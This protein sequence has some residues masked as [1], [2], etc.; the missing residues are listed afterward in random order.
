M[1][2]KAGTL[3]VLAQQVGQALQPLGDQ[4]SPDNLLPFLAGLGLQFPRELTAQTAFMSAA[5]AGAVAAGGL[6]P[7]L[8]RLAAAVASDDEAGILAAGLTL[9][10]QIGATVAALE[11]LGS[12]LASIAGSLPGMDASEVAGFAATLGVDLLDSLLITYLRG[13]APGAVGVAAALGLVEVLPQ[14]GVPFDPTHPPFLRQRFHLA[15]LGKLL[16]SPTALLRTLYDWGD[17]AFDATKLLP[18]LGA[19]FDLLGFSAAVSGDGPDMALTSSLLRVQANPATSPPGLLATIRYDIASG[20]DLTLPL[21]AAWSVRVQA[22]GAIVAGIAAS[23]APPANLTLLPPSGTLD[24]LLRM[25]LAAKGADAAHPFILLGETGGSRLQADTLG[26]GAGLAL[27]WDAGSGRAIAEPQ[28]QLTVAGGKAVVDTTNADGFLA[29]VLGGVH[30]EA[31][32]DLGVSWAPDTG[33]H[34]TGGAQLEIDL[35]L[36]LSLGP[37]TLSTLYLVA[38]AGDAGVPLEVSAALGLT[39][40][41]LQVAV[42]RIG[43]AGLLSFPDH[44]GNLGPADLALA[45][46][47][48][49]GLGIAIDAGVVAGGGY[50]QFDPQQGRYAGVLEVTLAEVIQVKVVAVLDTRLPDGSHGYSFLLVI[51]FDLPPI[52]LGL[53]FTLDG[54]GGLGAVNRTLDAAALQAGLRA[55]T[56]DRIL[57]PPDPIAN[58]PQIVA[59]IETLFPP[60]GGRYLFGPMLEIGWGTPTLITFQVGIVLE[61]PDPVRLVL[62]GLI[63]AGLPTAAAALVEIHVDVLGQL[64]FGAKTLAIDGTLHDSRVLVYALAGDLALRLAWGDDPNFVFALGGCNPHFDTTG[65]DLPVL[66]R[67]SLG[68]GNG[69]NPRLSSNSYLAVTSSTVQFGANVEVQASAADFSLHGYLGFDALFILSP[70]SFTVDF[71]ADL[72]VAFDGQALGGLRI[73]GLFSGPRPWHLH[74]DVSIDILFFSVSASLDLTWGDATPAI[75]PQRAVLPDLLA[76]LAE[77]RNWQAALPDGAALAVTLASA[78]PGGGGSTLRVHPVGVL[79]VRERIVPLDLT[80][81]RYANAAPADGDRFA[82]SGVRINGVAQATQAVQDDFATGQFLALSDADKLSA[83]SFERYDAGVAIGSPAVAAGTDSPR[84]VTYQ[85]RYVDDPAGFSRLAR[86]YTMPAATHLALARQA[87]GFAAPL[88][89]TG[90]ARYAAPATAAGAAGAAVATRETAY[91]VTRVADLSLRADIVPAAGGSFFQARAA[92]AD[93]LATHPEEAGDLQVLA[94]HEAAA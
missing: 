82:V 74:A 62:L 1:A 13:L 29:S 63:D 14:P 15:N 5:S 92:L 31:A 17:P 26:F 38:G 60:A 6:P 25:D 70:F 93:Y 12:E 37:V 72:D 23:L 7:L 53:G 65:L 61:V 11:R 32:F 58:A 80:I 8:A 34:V 83:P 86:P 77:P 22:Q 91:V 52:Q 33:V 76:A 89:N 36:H 16:T 73:D 42:D 94:A 57:F 18:V 24:G 43:L 2:G 41:P 21:G 45:F 48:P 56:L 46:K 50:V 81:A 55:H 75:L 51:T 78:G 35:P 3:E 90:L 40:G 71:S 87:A 69:D 44:G 27:H 84:T 64:D 9:V 67:L 66:R 59:A 47:P 68:L 39:L 19:A 28:V 54:V 49:G 10:Q 85:E 4:L 20:L 30:V 79:S 88:R